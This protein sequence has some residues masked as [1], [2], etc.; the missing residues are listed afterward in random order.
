MLYFA[1]WKIVLIVGAV[2][3][4]ILA[5]LPN[6][7][8]KSSVENWPSWLPHRQIVL[9]LDLQGGAYLLYQVDRQDYEQKRLTA[10]VGD[11]RTALREDPRIGYTGLGVADNGAQ[12]RIRDTAQ[13]EDAQERLAD[14]VNPLQSTLFGQGTV[15][16]FEM[17]TGEGGLIRFT[18]TED[19]LAQRIRSI[20]QQS[21]EVIR[22]R[23]DEL[24][25]TEPS[26]QREGEDR[27][28]VEAP[29]LDDPQ[30]LKALVG[31]TAQLTFHLVDNSVDPRQAIE[32]R[33][34]PGTTV[35][36]SL[37]DPPQPY[38]VEE[39][40]L[41]NGEDLTDAQA[42]FNQQT[43]EP[44]VTFRLSTGGA[45][46]FGNVTSN[47]VGRPFAIVL[48]NEVISA[49]V[50]REPILGGS[51]QISGNFTV[52]T[53]NDLAILLR[54]GAL[55]AKLEIVEERTVGPGLGQD[56]I[57]AGKIA[58]VAA[59]IGVTLSMILVYGLFGV[60]AN[61]ALVANVILILALLSLLQATLT[62]PGIAG[63]VLT[64]GMAVDANVLIYE[65]IRE[66]AKSGR[67]A[68]T[69]IDTGFSRALGTILD[70]NITTLIAAVILFQLGSGPVRGF[71]VT[72]AIGIVTT[73]FSAFLFTRLLVAQWV[74]MKRPSAIPL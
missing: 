73:V 25:T 17:T 27:I 67:S 74:R 16:E 58:A 66:E 54:A 13:F 62:L 45:R 37:D 11:I 19:G 33:P 39:A 36:Y 4:G 56:S 43:N 44:V 59:V 20:V 18:F 71:A 29:G 52:Q 49:P 30:R 70:A 65:R 2:I 8:P 1:R 42:T 48:D 23:I 24:G 22:R 69:A 26:I 68:I 10:L 12:V 21:I 15:N 3:L 35:L 31:Q 53:A 34:P 50:I 5:V 14:L 6:L 63:I 47:N 9:G 46:K 38:V 61:I 40:P 7:F 55:P 57:E 60:F 64:M 28:L 72:L 51:G 32:Q 41:L